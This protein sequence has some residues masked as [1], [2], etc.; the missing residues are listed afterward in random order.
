VFSQ[1]DESDCQ[2]WLDKIIEIVQK[3][4]CKW[5]SWKSFAQHFIKKETTGQK[6]KK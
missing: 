1:V 6:L 2:E 3:Q 5:F 4:P